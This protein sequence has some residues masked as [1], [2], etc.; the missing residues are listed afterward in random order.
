MTFV[1]HLCGD[2]EIIVYMFLPVLLR[3]GNQ[4]IAVLLTKLLLCSGTLDSEQI[5]EWVIR[6]P[7]ICL[8]MI[9]QLLVS[10]LVKIIC[11]IA[12]VHL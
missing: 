11:N 10:Y 1:K 7:M 5:T 3:S 4:E 6:A 8:S 9:M 12:S 2:P